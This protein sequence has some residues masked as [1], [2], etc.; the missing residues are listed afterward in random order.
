MLADLPWGLVLGLFSV[1]GEVE[2]RGWSVAT[3]PEWS[4]SNYRRRPS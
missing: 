4:L 3:G 2:W 1:V